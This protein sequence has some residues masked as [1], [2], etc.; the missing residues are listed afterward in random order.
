MASARG[1]ALCLALCL[2][3][4]P[5][6]QHGR[7]AAAQ[8]NLT[9]G[10]ALAP[11]GYITSP[12][13]AFAFGFR[14]LAADPTQFILATWLRV[15]GAGAGN[16]PAPPQSVVWFAKKADAGSTATATA[17]SALTI[18]PSGQLA[19][20]DGANGSDSVLWAPP[21][22][23]TLRRASA[24]A[25]LDSGDLRLLADGGGVL[26]QSF[27]HP[28][29]TLLPGQSVARDAGAQGKLVAK[30]ADAEF[31]TGR[32]S[33]AV[34][35]DGNVALY[36]DLLAGNDPDNAYWQAYTNTP[37]AA[38]AGGGG[39]GGGTVVSFDEHGRLYYTLRNG[40]EQ[41]LVPPM[42]NSTVGEYY[43]FARMDPDGIVRVYT[44]PKNGSAGGGGGGNTSWT[45][46]G[47]FPTDGCSR[48]TPGL[49]G[50]C[51]PGSYCVE[52]KDRLICECPGAYT[53]TDAQHRDAGC[54]PAFAPQSCDGEDNDD[55]PA[56][57]TFVELPN[58]TWRTS[59]HYKTLSPATEQ[60]CRDYCLH[61]CFCAAALLTGGTEC[62]EMAA[63]TNGRQAN[64]VAAKA[65]IKVRT[66]SNLPAVP[67]P[68]MTL[69]YKVT[70]GCL[71]FISLAAI[72]GLL[73]QRR[74]HK[75]N[76]AR[77]R[78]LGVRA[79]TRKELHDATNGFEKLLGRGSFG[80]VYLGVL[81]SPPPAQA[82]AV[83][84]LVASDE[85]SEREF[86]NEVQSLGQIHHRNLVRM[87]GYCKEGTH[88]MLVLEFMPGGSL[89]GALFKPGER[90]PPWPW[91]AEAALGVAR[92]LEYLHDGCASPI[93]HC[94]VKP[95]NILIDGARAA[96]ITD[97]GISKLLGG[98][99]VHATVTNVRGT[100]G[101]IAPEWLRGE[102]RVDTKADV[103][104]FGV[105]LLE[106]VCCR[107]C[108]EPVGFAGD[109]T[110]TLFGWAAQLVG[111][112]RTEL[113][114]REDD[115]DGDGDGDGDDVAVE[116]LE[117]VERF[118]R[119]ALWC[120]EPNPAHRPTM[121]QVVQMLEGAA[122]HADDL[123]DPPACY[124]E[125]SPLI[126]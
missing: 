64:G 51:G 15:P 72:A 104:S 84:K 93:I 32:F 90:R 67:S 108:Q 88:R 91:R 13:G 105:V 92:G 54:A 82:V 34:Q 122:V 2:L 65:L 58:T 120:M 44:R 21:V 123:P 7:A 6:Q 36:V 16:D 59:L 112:R 10:Q 107:R 9:A 61:D 33:L 3:V 23:S 49:Q 38:A 113:M 74:L 87:V 53:H 80:E 43:Q 114:L 103:Y 110:V 69:A 77:Q 52:T 79:F 89:R 116:E 94:D 126:P 68:G 97:F 30:R 75:K 86:A 47:A 27:A 31:T 106:T 55:D 117:R 56:A 99:R 50:L 29:D 18:R 42:P 40:T 124:L 57:F 22:N 115:G 26:W 46:S 118:A 41:N 100:R 24:L 85:H 98:E 70:T 121:H 39:G 111:A 95:D 45:V 73:A 71:A 28:R 62:A 19:L 20:V 48:S 35:P 125:S 11:P 63:L 78:L 12:S 76:T 14:A 25:L 66:T 5:R 1:I 8:T 81:R 17:R 37:A 119:V 101:Y 102:A 109:E 60:Q 4:L 83:K 96:R